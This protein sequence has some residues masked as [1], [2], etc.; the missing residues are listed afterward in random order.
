[1]KI[2]LC[3]LSITGTAAAGILTPLGTDDVV[4]AACTITG[5]LD[6]TGNATRGALDIIGNTSGRHIGIASSNPAN[7]TCTVSDPNA[8]HF[9]VPDTLNPR[10]STRLPSNIRHLRQTVGAHLR[11]MRTSP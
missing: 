8:V 4:R 7:P 6:I 11:G 3:P 5:G 1:L 2:S 9:C 10:D